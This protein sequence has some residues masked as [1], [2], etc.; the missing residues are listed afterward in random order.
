MSMPIFNFDN[1]K[2]IHM[3]SK[4]HGDKWLQARFKIAIHLTSNCLFH[5]LRELGAKKKGIQI[6]RH[7]PYV[8]DHPQNTLLM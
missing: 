3:S 4:N 2:D 6:N 7:L 8:A 5:T 1:E